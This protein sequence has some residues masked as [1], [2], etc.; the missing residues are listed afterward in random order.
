MLLQKHCCSKQNGSENF[1]R[2]KRVHQVN[3]CSKFLLQMLWLCGAAS[4]LPYFCYFIL[5]ILIVIYW[6]QIKL[7]CCCCCCYVH[8]FQKWSCKYQIDGKKL[9]HFIHWNSYSPSE[10]YIKQQIWALSHNYCS[11][12]ITWT[13]NRRLWK[14]FFCNSLCSVNN[15]SH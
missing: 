11:K 13:I 14:S 7:C 12:T 4:T 3:Y 10:Y 2:V 5:F 9:S 15:F 6:V 1:S 8:W